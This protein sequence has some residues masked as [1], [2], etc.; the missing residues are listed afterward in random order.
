MKNLYGE[1]EKFTSIFKQSE[2]HRNELKKE[3][4]NIVSERI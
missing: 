1:S 4:E 3:Y 2:Q